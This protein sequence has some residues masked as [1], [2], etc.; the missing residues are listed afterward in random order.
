MAD[1]LTR[2]DSINH[3]ELAGRTPVSFDVVSLYTNIN[4]EEAINTSLD[5]A[6]KFNLELHGLTMENLWELLRL[7]LDNNVF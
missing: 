7:I 4:V 3:S 5:Y 1:L 6:L 2:F